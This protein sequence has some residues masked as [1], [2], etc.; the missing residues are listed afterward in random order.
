[1]K[2]QEVRQIMQSQKFTISQTA[3]IARV[4]ESTVPAWLRPVTNK[5]YREPSAAS[6]HLLRLAIIADMS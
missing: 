5:A 2:S 4:S 1:M 6:L 3:T